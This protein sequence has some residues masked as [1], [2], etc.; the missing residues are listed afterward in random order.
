MLISQFAWKLMSTLIFAPHIYLRL[1]NTH[2]HT[3]IHTLIST[4]THTNLHSHKKP[5]THQTLS[6]TDSH[7]HIHKLKQR[8][9]ERGRVRVC[10][11]YRLFCTFMRW[12]TMLVGDNISSTYTD[13]RK[14]TRHAFSNWIFI[15]QIEQNSVITKRPGTNTI[16]SL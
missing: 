5:F 6:Y 2:T 15:K 1:H 11:F 8:K 7:K 16:C 12:W 9:R 14:K 4:H 3:Y 13:L 10:L